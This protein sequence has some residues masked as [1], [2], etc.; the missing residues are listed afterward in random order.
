MAAEASACSGPMST[1]CARTKGSWLHD[2]SGRPLS[3]NTTDLPE[4][5]SVAVIDNDSK[6]PESQLRPMRCQGMSRR[7]MRSSCKVFTTPPSRFCPASTSSMWPLPSSVAG[8]FMNSLT[9]KC[10]TSSR[11]MLCQR[12]ASSRPCAAGMSDVPAMKQAWI[13]PTE[14]PQMMSKWTWPPRSPARS[15]R[16]YRRTPAS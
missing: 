9:P 8:V 5:M 14:V 1:A 7:T 15:S 3:T 12:S 16:R 11:I 6:H 13:P 10:T 2:G 4:P